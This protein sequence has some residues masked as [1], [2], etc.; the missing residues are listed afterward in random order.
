MAKFGKWI[1]G[2]LGWAMGGPIGLLFGF[3]LGSIV[4]GV[5]SV[6][7]PQQSLQTTTGGY[8]MSMLVLIAAVM[9]A[10]GKIL[11]SELAYVRHFF[12]HN[13]GEESASEAILMLRDLLNQSIPV[14]DVC[15]QIKNNM[16]Y[17]S[18][19]QLLH[20]L[21]GLSQSDG[22]VD[23]QELEVIHH[24]S[25]EL[26][27]TE[28][29]YASIKAMFVR[30]TRADY[31]ILEIEPTATDEEIKQAYRKMAKKYHPD[32]VSYLGDDFQKAAKEKFQKVN[33][34]YDNLKKERNLV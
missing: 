30:D 4:D 29:E 1:G 18:R 24:I 23:P 14:T 25:G 11:K 15:H 19:L 7:Q 5:S 27:I 9:K 2:G 28:N 6:G 33:E 20:F 22:V 3:V 21:F 32:K 13:F 16:N 26:G 31:T 12:V 34:A 8:I 10:D 17:P